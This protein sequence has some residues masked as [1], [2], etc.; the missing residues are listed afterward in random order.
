MRL[1]A[2]VMVPREPASTMIFPSGWTAMFVGAQGV[3]GKWLRPSVQTRDRVRP[4]RR[5]AWSHNRACPLRGR[6]GHVRG[7]ITF[8]FSEAPLAH[9]YLHDRKAKGKV[10][11]VPD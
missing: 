10:L 1:D 2:G 3:T 8:P 11:L 6:L 5:S 9:H 4:W 7:T